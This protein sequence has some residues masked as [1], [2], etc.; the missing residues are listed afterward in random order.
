MAK[1]NANSAP[2]KGKRAKKAQSDDDFNEI[3]DSSNN[4]NNNDDI[5]EADEDKNED[6][7]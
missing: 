7:E 4:N 6:G 3:D 5:Y 1:T 2:N